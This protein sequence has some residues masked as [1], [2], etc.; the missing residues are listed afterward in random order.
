[1]VLECGKDVKVIV[2]WDSGRW[3]KQMVMVFMYG[4]MEIDMKV[5]L[6]LV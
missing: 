5:I 4:L 6:K 3:E 1:M 2:M